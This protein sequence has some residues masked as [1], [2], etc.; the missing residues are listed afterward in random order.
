[1]AMTAEAVVFGGGQGLGW[2]WVGRALGDLGHYGSICEALS[3]SATCAVPRQAGC[4]VHRS[5]PCWQCSSSGKLATDSPVEFALFGPVHLVHLVVGFLRASG[6]RRGAVG[7]DDLFT[8]QIVRE[9]GMLRR[10]RGRWRQW[11]P[12]ISVAFW[13]RWSRRR[14]RA[15]GNRTR[16]RARLPSTA[17]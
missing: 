13:L 17:M 3:G 11:L 4:C 16:D 12:V 1:L 9:M 10:A 14:W 8:R 5:R 6:R 2:P 7:H 15:I